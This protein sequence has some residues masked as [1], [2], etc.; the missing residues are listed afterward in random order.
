MKKLNTSPLSGMQELLPEL[1]AEFDRLKS[2]I[3]QV[4][5]QAG[6][7]HIETPMIERD[8]ILLAK[9][10]GE[11]E[12]Q[13]YR[14]IKTTETAQEADQALRFDHTVSLARYV[15]EHLNDLAFPFRVTQSA[16]NFRGERAQKG[17]FREFYQC[18]IDVVGRNSLPIEYDAEVIFTLAEALSTLPLPGKFRVRVSNRKLLAG[19]LESLNLERQAEK[20]LSIIDHAEKVPEN[21]TR[22]ALEELQIGSENM[23]K[24]MALIAVAGEKCEIIAQLKALGPA[25]ATFE[26]G[27]AE[28]EQ[29]LWVLEQLQETSQ[30]HYE[31]VADLKIV[32]G[33]DYYT[34]TVFETVL[35]THPEI[36]SICS[37]GRYE[38]LASHYT[39][40]SLPGVGGSIG[41]TRLF[42]VLQDLDAISMTKE[43]SIDY[44]LLTLGEAEQIVEATL[45][46][47]QKLRKQ[48]ATVDIVWGAKKLGDKFKYASKVAEKA[49]VIGEMEAEK[50]LNAKSN[51]QSMA[52]TAKMLD[53][54]ET[55]ELFF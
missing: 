6:F 38:N 9:A 16:R 35:D 11:T 32:R 20:I 1:Q 19:V 15:V 28:L 14:V 46:V 25:N 44:C 43:K 48:G 41:L 42:S 47:A 17:R 23:Q 21:V 5:R 12:K 7:Q 13:I 52:L 45:E 27:L 55:I 24:I 2:S 50:I 51:D 22:E 54:G 36:G 30:E 53:S 34:G 18:D 40:Q 29:V 26:A 4:Y 39:D 10:G 49:I 3:Q 33:L 31:I 37:G 8:E